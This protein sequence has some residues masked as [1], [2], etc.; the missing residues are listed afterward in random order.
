MSRSPISSPARDPPFVEREVAGAHLADDLRAPVQQ[1]HRV[2]ALDRHGVG[3]PRQS[4]DRPVEPE[5]IAVDDEERRI[6]EEAGGQRRR[7]RA[8]GVAERLLAQDRGAGRPGAGCEMRLDLVGLPVGIDHDLL[9]A[10]LG[11]PVE[12]VIEQRAALQRQHRLCRVRGQRPHARAEAGGQD[13][14]EARVD[15][16]VRLGVLEQGHA[17]SIVN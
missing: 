12:C 4:E 15:V 14:C 17:D 1:Q 11:Q 9:D 5:G 16:R 8:A 13:H 3:Q 6:A 2:R 10:R 7:H